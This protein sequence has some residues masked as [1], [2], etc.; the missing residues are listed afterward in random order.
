MSA[1]RVT[2][3]LAGMIRERGAPVHI[4]SDNGSEFI[5]YAI[6]HWLVSAAGGRKLYVEP[7]SPW[8]NGYVESFHSRLRDELLD[9][10]GIQQ[11]AE[12]R[13][14]RRELADG[15]RSEETA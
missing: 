9:R 10:G 5:A 8:E 13:W 7:G 11:P 2:E 6:R 1:S 3:L 12:A 14:C 4:R 15:V